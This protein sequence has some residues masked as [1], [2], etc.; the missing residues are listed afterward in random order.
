MGRRRR[1]R[2]RDKVKVKV[3]FITIFHRLTNNGFEIDFWC[4]DTRF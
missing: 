4:T 2:R 1:R 3:R